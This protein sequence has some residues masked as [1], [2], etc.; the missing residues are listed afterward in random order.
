MIGC[1]TGP[2][3]SH[4]SCPTGRTF[5]STMFKLKGIIYGHTRPCINNSI[6]P[7]QNETPTPPETISIFFDNVS[8]FCSIS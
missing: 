6:C 2:A 1:D 3:S 5:A 4:L 8:S 7:T